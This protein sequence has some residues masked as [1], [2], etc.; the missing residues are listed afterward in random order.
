MSPLGGTELQYQ[1]LYKYV[2]NTLLDNFLITTSVPEKIPLSK[3]KIN[4]LW[5]QN[6]YDQPNLIDWFSNKDN[7]KKYDFYVFNSHWCYEKFRMRFKIPCH[8]S[9]VIK[10]AVERF[11]EKIFIRKKKVK[12]IYH[13]TP[14]RGLNVL[15]GAMQLV[16][17]KDVELDVYSSTQIYGDQFKKHNDDQYKGLY[18]QAKALP[19]VNYIG[20]VSN[21]EIRK[22][23]QEYD[24]Y[25][26][27]SIW[28]ETSC[29]SA[30]EALT[31]GLHMITTNYGALFETCSEWPVYVNYTKDYKDLAKL[32]AFSIDEVC[33]Y[34]Y[35]GTVPDFL[36][37]QQAFYNDFYSW[38][39]R[40]SEWSQF[41]Q[42]LLNEHRSKL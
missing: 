36:K 32:F 7:H 15:L 34:L 31:A 39:R 1:L 41:L 30:I 35:K 8:K 9:T 10:N 2:D 37:R 20:Y 40:K 21:E 19:N 23:L 14:W 6:S 27:P 38:D 42:G 16:K 3:D 28:E 25:C 24:L 11:P 4:I 12:L 18:E 33:N 17:N 26:F 29:I 5:Q 13:S 22:K